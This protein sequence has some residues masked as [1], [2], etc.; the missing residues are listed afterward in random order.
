MN[1]LLRRLLYL[2]EQASSYARELDYLHYLIILVTMAGSTA[3][4]AAALYFY[5]RYKRRGAAPAT[6]PEVHIPLKQE[7]ALA[8]GL[9]LLFILFWVI[10]F[11]QFVRMSQPPR[12]AM[13]V[14][15]MGKQWM[16]KFA[17]PEGPSSV[18]TLY[19][20]A[21]R[22]VRLLITSRD[23]IHS[24]FVPAFRLKQDAVPGRY[25]V[26]WFEATK[27]GIYPAYCTEYCGTAHSMMRADV[28]VLDPADFQRWLASPA[29]QASAV[30]PRRP[31]PRTEAE[32]RAADLVYPT[33]ARLGLV[34]QGTEVA[35]QQG[36][37]RCHSLDGTPHIGPT[38]RGV[39]GTL[40]RLEGGGQVLAD[41]AYLTESMMDPLAKI[42]AGYPPVMPSYRGQ[43]SPAET[44]AIVELIKSLHPD[45]QTGRPGSVEGSP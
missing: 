38:W 21:G 12:D 36:C 41:E 13:D 15:V 6:T 14:Y 3:V 8:L 9:L 45:A 35:A 31:G 39:F 17:Y 18:G 5:F 26:A 28:V 25:T 40:V 23:V 43:I 30:D 27:T 16:W 11:A 20:P 44:A 1:D 10:G 34:R 24:F 29:A 7:I 2:P 42:A 4:F 32:E 33:S 22:P 19:V 37:L